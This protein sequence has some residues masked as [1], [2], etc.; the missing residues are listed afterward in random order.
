MTGV[1][2]FLDQVLTDADPCRC[3]HPMNRH[4]GNAAGLHAGGCRGPACGCLWFR[5]DGD[6]KSAATEEVGVG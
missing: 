3:S 4:K 2:E 6:G 1:D 5:P